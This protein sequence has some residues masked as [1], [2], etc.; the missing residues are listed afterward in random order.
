VVEDP[1]NGQIIALA[2][3]PSYDPSW[4]VGGISP[5][6]FDQLKNDPSIPLLDRTIQGQYAPGS[7]FKLITAIAG[8]K[9]GVITPTSWFNDTGQV[10]IGDPAHGGFIAHNDN[11]AVYGPIQLPTAITE[12]SDNFFNTI[13]LNLWYGRKQYGADALQNVA[14]QFGLGRP[15]GITLPNEA[16][17]KIPTPESYI[18]DHLA[19]PGVFTQSQWYPANSDQMAIGQDEDLVTPLQLANA[20][21]AFANGGTLYAPQL[22]Q[23]AQTAAGVVKKEFAP[24][25]KNTI[26]LDPAWRSALLQGFEGVVNNPKGTAY[27]DFANTPLAGK[28][29]AGKTGTAQV[30]APRQDTSV[31]TSFAPASNPTY[32]V[33]AF[34][35]DAG[36]G[37]SVAAPVVREIY[38]QLFN[39]PLQPVTYSN[40]G[41]GGQN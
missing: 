12:S 25:V 6:H 13:G 18:K 32:V 36:Y 26:Q 30:N 1:R 37:A 21:A 4:W 15:T 27:Y 24:E 19:K 34:V 20:Y 31:F 2:T 35:E 40:G 11:N 5:A 10:V 7:T 3:D 17:G 29:I 14:A 28:D 23:D 9:Y 38:D 22:V 16:S 8:L 39:V 41:S 33:D